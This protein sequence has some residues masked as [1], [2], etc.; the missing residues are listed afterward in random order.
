MRRR[1]LLF[2]AMTLAALPMALLAEGAI[3]V[4]RPWARA[5]AGAADHGV[6]YLTLTHTG[7]DSDKLVGAASPRA[8]RVEIHTHDV[9][10]GVVRMRRV[11]AV[12]LAPGATTLFEPGALHL[13]L[14]GLTQPLQQDER[15][16]LTLT[17]EHQDEVTV[18]VPVGPAGARGPQQGPGS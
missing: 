2:A 4:E 3:T 8:E 16:A 18:E 5:S 15:F 10:D 6:A 17:F 7:S 11:A 1:T 13:M 12:A 9:A 14:I